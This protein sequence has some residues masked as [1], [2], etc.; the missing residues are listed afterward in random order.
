MF[1]SYPQLSI[2]IVFLWAIYYTNR[3]NEGKG[4]EWHIAALS[5]SYFFLYKLGPFGHLDIIII[6]SIVF[7]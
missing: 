3:R 1:N 7:L 2:L 4:A 5:F 6:F